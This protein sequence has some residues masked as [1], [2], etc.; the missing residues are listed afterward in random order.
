MWSVIKEK[1]GFD[2]MNNSNQLIIADCSTVLI[3]SPIL[4]KKIQPFLA[5]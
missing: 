5:E 3:Y 4:I 1:P 2:I